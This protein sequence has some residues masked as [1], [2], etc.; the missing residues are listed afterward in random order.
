MLYI[1]PAIDIMDRHGLVSN[2]VFH[3]CLLWEMKILLQLLGIQ[4]IR[5]PNE[6]QD[7]VGRFIYK[8]KQ[9]YIV[10]DLKKVTFQFHNI[11]A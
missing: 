6:Q 1:A 11:S 5:R 2:K 3:E 10:K 9:T 8:Y 7:M 4:F